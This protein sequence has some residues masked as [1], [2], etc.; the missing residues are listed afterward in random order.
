MSDPAGPGFVATL[1]LQLQTQFLG[2][3]LHFFTTIDSTNTYAARLAREGAR[4]G[5]AVIADSQSGGQGG[6]GRTWGSP[7]S[8]NLYLSVILRPPVPLATVPQLNLLAA[9]AVVET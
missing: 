4:E 9:V 5:T 6:V 2:K 7:S 3:P 1:S 8:V